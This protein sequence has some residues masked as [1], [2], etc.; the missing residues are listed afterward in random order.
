M[1]NWSAEFEDLNKFCTENSD[2]ISFHD[3]EN[4]HHLDS[5]IQVLKMNER[6][7]ICT[8]Y[9]ARGRDSR[10]QSHLP[11]FKREKTGAI[12]WGLVAGKTQTNFP[13]G[14]KE[15]SPEPVPWHHDIF[16]IDGSAYDTT[17]TEF[18]RDF[19]K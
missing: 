9:M 18:L 12:N 19:L 5:M 8:E 14:S 6:P 7:L 17:E 2:I 16:R 10:F 4:V 13:W 1:W 3:Y 11:V 15:G